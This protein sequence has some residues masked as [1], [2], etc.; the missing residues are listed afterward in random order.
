MTD[1]RNAQNV[2]ELTAADSARMAE[3]HAAAFSQGGAWGP[4]QFEDL[5]SQNSNRAFAITADD[6]ILSFLLVQ[7]ADNQ[8]EIL[9]IATQPSVR[10]RGLAAALLARIE[11]DLR[12]DGIATWLLDVAADNPSAIEFYR[13]LGFKADGLRPKYYK[14]LEGNRVDA[15]LMSKPMARQAAT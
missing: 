8:A 9:T 3:L 14:R 5:L 12:L 4:Q 15:I 2:V 6:K 1:P 13:K 10:R 7:T 11:A